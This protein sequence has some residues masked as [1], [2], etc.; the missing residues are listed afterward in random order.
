MLLFAMSVLVVAQSSSEIPEGLANNHVLHMQI[1]F[2]NVDFIH[3]EKD[4]PVY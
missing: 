3:K 4:V 1:T 2:S